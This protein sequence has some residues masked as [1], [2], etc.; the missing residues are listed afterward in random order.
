MANYHDQS[1]P[2]NQ[3]VYDLQAAGANYV[4]VPNAIVDRLCRANLGAHE[5]RVL[6]ALIR[7]TFGW[8]IDR[9]VK[10]L[11]KIQD[12]IALSQFEETTGLDR[13]RVHEALARLIARRIITV[14]SRRATTTITYKISWELDEWQL[15]YVARA[16]SKHSN[17]VKTVL[18]ARTSTVPARQDN[19]S[20]SGALTLSYPGAPTK[21]RIKEEIK[22]KDKEIALARGS[23]LNSDFKDSSSRRSSEEDTAKT[24]ELSAYRKKMWKSGLFSEMEMLGFINQTLTELMT[25]EAARLLERNPHIP[26]PSAAAAQ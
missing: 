13:R 21:E 20:Y 19:L 15:S 6:W 10:H 24:K 25:L 7:K 12:K 4:P 11:R 18:A 3:E 22:E 5:S 1:D 8:C 17:R 2:S 14:L 9:D 23:L 26:S 16:V